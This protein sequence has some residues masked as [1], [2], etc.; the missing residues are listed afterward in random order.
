[1]VDRSE[2]VGSRTGDNH[3]ICTLSLCARSV[4]GVRLS[5]RRHGPISRL[6]SGRV[7][8]RHR[9]VVDPSMVDRSELVG[10]RT[11]DNH[12]ICTLS[13]PRE[14]ESLQLLALDSVCC[15]LRPRTALMRRLRAHKNCEASWCAH[16]SELDGPHTAS[17]SLSRLA[18]RGVC[19]LQTV[20]SPLAPRGCD[21]RAAVGCGRWTVD[22]WGRA[23]TT[24]VV[25][26][27]S[28]EACWRARVCV[29]LVRQACLCACG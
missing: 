26:A 1:M 18:A 8:L 11:G 4:A 15:S 28:P 27:L 10:S 2:L 9:P 14:P 25:V 24:L 6:S 29:A 19:L 12:E 13:L 22:R 21:L 16:S 7:K 20:R 23:A 5:A 17:P 3:E